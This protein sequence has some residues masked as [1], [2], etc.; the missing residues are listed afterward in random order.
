MLISRDLLHYWQKQIAPPA[1]LCMQRI[2][3]LDNQFILRVRNGEVCLDYPLQM[4]LLPDSYKVMQELDIEKIGAIL[5]TMGEMVRG[6]EPT[7]GY[8]QNMQPQVLQP[9]ALSEARWYHEL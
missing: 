5:H 1:Q 6:S 2:I 3:G 7:D 9:I 8:Y 4:P